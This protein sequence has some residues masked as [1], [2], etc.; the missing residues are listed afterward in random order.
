VV[1]AIGLLGLAERAGWAWARHWPLAFLA[2]AAMLFVR[3]DPETWPLGPIGFFARLADPEVLQHRLL[4]LLIV[5]FA[6]FEWLVRTHRLKGDWPPLVF[7]LVCAIGGALL[8]THSHSLS[9][10]KERYLIEVSHIPMGFFG[11]IGGWSRWLELRAEGVTR[12]AAGWVWPLC[13]AAI[14]LLL[15][16]YREM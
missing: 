13:F 1:L 15:L 8:L 12:R 16:D 5:V 11:I 3:S 10:V 4:T 7:P 9:D 14:G 2:L 6:V